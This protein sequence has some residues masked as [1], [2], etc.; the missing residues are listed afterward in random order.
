MSEAAFKDTFF[1]AL[2]VSQLFKIDA[3][4]QL[5]QQVKSFGQEVNHM[6]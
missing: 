5:Y 2:E 3:F 6:T 1:V 4:L